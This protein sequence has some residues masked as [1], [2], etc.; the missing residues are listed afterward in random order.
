MKYSD[1][2]LPAALLLGGVY[3]Y[4]SISGVA[5]KFNP[6][7]RDNFIYDLVPEA[8]GDWWH[9]INNRPRPDLA[10]MFSGEEDPQIMCIQ[11]PC[12]Q[13]SSSHV[14]PDGTIMKGATHSTGGY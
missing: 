7:N 9:E 1:L 11:A 13:R 2:I 14:M 6:D 12:P 5:G 8:V 3:L 10:E 4:R